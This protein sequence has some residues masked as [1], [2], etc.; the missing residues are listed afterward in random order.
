MSLSRLWYTGPPMK[1]D[2]TDG[3]YTVHRRAGAPHRVSGFDQLDARR[4]STVGPT[5]RGG[6]PRASGGMASRWKTADGP[7]VHRVQELSAPDA[8]RSPV[9]HSQLP[10]NLCAPGG[11]GAPVRHGPEQS[12]AVDPCPFARI[13]DT[14][15]TLGGA[16]ARSL[17][18]LVQRLA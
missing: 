2:T 6:V 14:L 13:T 7:P 16:P 11:P 12:Q 18:A 1:G 4:V 5:F 15:R 17:T 3:Q 9:L 10:E 8:G